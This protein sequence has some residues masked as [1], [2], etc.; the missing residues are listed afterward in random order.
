MSV[1]QIVCIDNTD[2]KLKKIP[3][4]ILLR[5]GIKIIK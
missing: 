5:I 1:N 2:E 4:F 3:E